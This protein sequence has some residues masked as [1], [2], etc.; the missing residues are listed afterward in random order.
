MSTPLPA[1][2]GVA[3]GP[4]RPCPPQIFR[5]Y[6][7]WCFERRYHKQNSVIRIKSNILSPPNFLTPKFVGWLRYYL[8]G[9]LPNL[10]ADCFTVGPYRVI[11]T[12]QQ[13]LN[14]HFKLRYESFCHMWLLNA[15][16]LASNVAR[17]WLLFWRPCMHQ[18]IRDEG[19]GSQLYFGV[20]E[21]VFEVLAN[22]INV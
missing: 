16:I 8:Q 11:I 10:R 2:I 5:T 14:V 4:R 19:I 3:R 6:S 1:S 12:W 18:T 22:G 13:I 7:H 21:Y 9:K 17:Q 20:H 15:D